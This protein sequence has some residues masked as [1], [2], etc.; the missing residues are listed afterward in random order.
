MLFP[1]GADGAALCA[2][3]RVKAPGNISVLKEQSSESCAL[4]VSSLKLSQHSPDGQRTTHIFDRVYLI[5]AS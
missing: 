5:M 3:A 2:Q 1:A 4:F